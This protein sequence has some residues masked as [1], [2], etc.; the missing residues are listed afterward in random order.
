[1]T[2]G[3]LARS[4]SL[5]LYIKMDPFSSIPVLLGVSILLEIFRVAVVSRASE[6]IIKS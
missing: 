6:M 1:V 3:Y 2:C 4:Y 5:G